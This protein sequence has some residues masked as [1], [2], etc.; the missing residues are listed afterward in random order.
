[1]ATHPG[2]PEPS[3][4]AE[5]VSRI[6]AERPQVLMVAY[7]APK[8]EMWIDRVGGSLSG[9]SVAIGVGGAFDYLTGR[10][11]R[12]PLWMRRSGMEWLFRLAYQPWRIRRM[13]VLPAYALRVLR[14]HS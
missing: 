2:S 10:V 1:V 8:Q 12:A 4:D 11:P 9:V 13:V 6:G 5:T 7:G 14:S 3:A